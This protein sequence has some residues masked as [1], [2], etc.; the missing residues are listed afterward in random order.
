MKKM[1]GKKLSEVF[2]SSFLN[3]L[4]RHSHK[5]ERDIDFVSSGGIVLYDFHE[6]N[7]LYNGNKYS[8]ID[9][10]E[11]GIVNSSLRAKEFNHRFHRVLIG[12][13]FLGNLENIKHTKVIRDN[14]TKYKYMDLK[15]S[16]M[17]F[18]VKDDMEKYTKEQIETVDDFNRIIRK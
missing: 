1:P 13:L 4:S 14:I 16:Q 17:I 12:N 9:P 10:D 15:P 2:S 6:D 8:V 18:Q 7:L 5:L 3:D 11:N